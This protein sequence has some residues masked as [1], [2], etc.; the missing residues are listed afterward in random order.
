MCGTTR[1]SVQKESP[2][3]IALAEISSRK[4]DRYIKNNVPDE[5]KYM[6]NVAR[7][8]TPGEY[9]KAAGLAVSSVRD[10][11]D[12]M[13]RQQQRQ[14][15][16]GGASPA[17]GAYLMQQ[18]S[19]RGTGADAISQAGLGARM[20][21]RERYLGNIQ[22]IVG[23]GMNQSGQAQASMSGLAQTQ[24]ERAKANIQNKWEN[25]AALAGAAGT[26]IGMGIRG[27]MGPYGSGS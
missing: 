21:Q 16:A 8:D 14:S 10:Q 27:A 20:G 9:R 25:D 2:F 3:E 5:K 17:S 6:A 15:L 7:M 23:M 13:L 1:R 24:A 19:L 26:A 4:Y 11:F 22:N 18:A 12:P